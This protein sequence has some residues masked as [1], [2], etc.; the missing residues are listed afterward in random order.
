MNMRHDLWSNVVS[1]MGREGPATYAAI[2]QV[3][4]YWDALRRGRPMPR[5]AEVDPRGL[6][7]ALH[8]A[9]VAERVA[10]GIGRIR[11]AGQHL[12]DLLG[13]EVRG[14]PLTAFLAAGARPR[15]ARVL[16]QVTV[17]GRVA[18]LRLSAEA[19]PARPA[20][21]A[22]L[23]LGPLSSPR[24]DGMP[25]ALGCLES[26]GLIGRAPRRFELEAVKTRRIVPT[27]GPEVE[28]ELPEAPEIP[29]LPVRAPEPGFAE[30]Q[31]PFGGRRAAHLTLVKGD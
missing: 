29:A 27:A 12:S 30:A 4:G 11:I 8:F 18:E 22:R 6:E 26:H 3:D 5:R 25:Q 17:E 28:P 13:M 9:F 2:A 1:L 19:S 14:M 31:R 15:L 7:G 10:P 23:W 24:P 16:E 20:L 21:Q